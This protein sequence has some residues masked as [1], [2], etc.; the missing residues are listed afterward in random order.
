[1]TTQLY[2]VMSDPLIAAPPKLTCEN[3]MTAVEGVSWNSL[4]FQLDIPRSKRLEIA[5]QYSS[6]SQQCQAL[7][8]YWLGLDPSPSWRRVITALD[9]IS[10][11]EGPERADRIWSYAEPLTGMS[12]ASSRT[13]DPLMIHLPYVCLFPSL[14]VEI[15]YNPPPPPLAKL[16]ILS[17]LDNFSE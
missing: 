16:L 10:T 11:G 17:P 13:Y 12:S 15:S 9:G 8:Q 1:M 4:G 5:S 14:R 3:V 7:I 2:I 6:G